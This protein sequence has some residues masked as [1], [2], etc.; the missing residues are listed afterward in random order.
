MLG[1]RIVLHVETWP[2][3]HR[4]AGTNRESRGGPSEAHLQ[5][6][7]SCSAYT[8]QRIHTEALPASESGVYL[9]ELALSG[10]SSTDRF[11]VAAGMLADPVG[12]SWLK[13]S[14]T[15]SLISSLSDRTSS[16]SECCRSCI[17]CTG[18]YLC[19]DLWTADC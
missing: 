3:Q 19:D 15:S 7:L 14:S 13:G 18:W 10:C 1:C 2:R 6:P 17:F 9:D 5:C 16:C 8:L 11:Q 12:V 4:E